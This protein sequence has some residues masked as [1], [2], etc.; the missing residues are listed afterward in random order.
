MKGLQLRTACLFAALLI[1]PGGVNATSSTVVDD[2]FA[3]SDSQ[4]QDLAN[5]I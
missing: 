4:N 5:N 3:N 1:T 2:T